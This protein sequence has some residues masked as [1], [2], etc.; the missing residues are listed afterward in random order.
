MGLNAYKRTPNISMV[1][2]P[3]LY[4]RLIFVTNIKLS[5]YCYECASKAR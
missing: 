3:I 2:E 5:L 4:R 1:G